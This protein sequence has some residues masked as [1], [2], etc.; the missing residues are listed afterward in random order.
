M[1]KWEAAHR[2]TRNRSRH[3]SPARLGRFVSLDGEGF[4]RPDG[5][6]VYSLLQDSTGGRIEDWERGLSSERCFR[7]L[8]DAPKRFGGRLCGV[9]YGFDYDVNNFLRDVPREKLVFLH[10][11][12]EVKTGRWRLEWRPRKWFQVSELDSVSNRTVKGRSVRIYDTIGFYNVRFIDACEDWVGKEDPD[13]AL[14]VEGKDR[15]ST[16][17]PSDS[18]YMREYNEAELRL[19]VRL[20]AKLKEA[21]DTAG[22]DLTQF[23]GAGASAGALLTKI[24]FKRAINPEVPTEVR[25]AARHAYFG[26]RIEVPVYGNVPGPL[27]DYDLNSAYPS[28]ALDLPNITSGRWVRGK[29]YRPETPFSL[30]HVRWKLPSGRA[31]YPFPWRAPDGAIFFPPQGQAW[32]WS[33]ELKSALENGGFP[34]RAFRILESWHFSPDDPDDH[35][36]AVLREMYDL[37]KGFERDRNPAAKAIKLCLNAVYGKLA[38]SVSGMSQFGARDGKGRRPTFHQIEY[39]G[40]MASTCRARV[41]AAACQKPGAI[42]AFATDGILSREPLD[43]PISERLGE[44]DLEEFEAATLVQSGVYRLRRADGSWVTRG[45]GYAERSVSWDEVDVA[46]RE[47]KT[48]LEVVGR[49]QFVG[50][51]AVVS[52]GRWDLWR[53]FVRVPKTLQLTATGKRWDKHPPGRWT[54]ADNPATRPHLTEPT[55]P[56]LLGLA[57]GAEG[58]ESTPWVPKFEDPAALTAEEAA[59]SLEFRGDLRRQV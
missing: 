55:D 22:I 49:D 58:M 21:F 43:L 29:T 27:H 35:P 12:G 17:A 15:R 54:R 51:G 8:V 20:T 45:R 40:F 23:Y 19:M 38:Q 26:G 33:P 3:V 16:F 31:F 10:A 53:R 37:R 52:T 18:G 30:Y 39:A 2:A 47:C 24:G 9:S 48:T 56:F 28:A 25:R 42:L 5:S 14:V 46:W 11:H 32:V 6:H 34:K 50:L 36:L 57:R 59:E 44:W 7:F 41:Y 4:N 13:F 1:P